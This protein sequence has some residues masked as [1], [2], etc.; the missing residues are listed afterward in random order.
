MS[1]IVLGEDLW[2]EISEGRCPSAIGLDDR[3]SCPTEYDDNAESKCIKCWEK[4]LS[5]CIVHTTGDE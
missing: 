2:R 3:E 1:R 5:K 4:A